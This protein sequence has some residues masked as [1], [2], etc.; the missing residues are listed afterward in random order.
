MLR[1]DKHFTNFRPQVC[2]FRDKHSWKLAFDEFSVESPVSLWGFQTTRYLYPS[3]P[4]SIFLPRSVIAQ[5]AVYK[6]K[7]YIG[8]NHEGHDAPKVYQQP[9][10]LRGLYY[11][12]ITQVE[13]L[14][15]VHLMGLGRRHPPLLDGYPTLSLYKI[16]QGSMGYSLYTGFLCGYYPLIPS[17]RR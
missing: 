4:S 12:P 14:G 6:K 7:S 5:P 8:S 10:G 1:A 2:R 9:T 3:E 15:F 13:M 17:Y 11:N 16:V